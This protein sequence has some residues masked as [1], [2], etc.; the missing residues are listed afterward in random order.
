MHILDR[1]TKTLNHNLNTENHNRLSR[2]TLQVGVR[3]WNIE[4][5][6]IFLGGLVRE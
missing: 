6:F 4:G 3:V 2:Y 1:P 5:R